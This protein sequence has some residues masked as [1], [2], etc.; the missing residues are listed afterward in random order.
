[1]AGGQQLPE[2][3]TVPQLARVFHSLPHLNVSLHSVNNT[4]NP[5]SE[6]YLESLGI[7][8]SI[9]AAWLILTLLVLLVYLVTRCCDRK[10]R[11][12]RS[13]TL[14][15]CSLAILA[16]LCSGAVAVG[17][18]GNDDVHNGLVQLVA[19]A[20]NVDGI[21]MGVRNQTDTIETTL[22]KKVQLQLTALGDDFDAPVSNK[23]MLGLLLA[24]LQS[25]KQ[26]T[27]IAVNRSFEI[28]KPLSG[29]SLAG[30]IGM[31]EKIEQLRWPVTMAVLSALL[32]LCVVLVVGVARHS[33]CVLITFSVFGLFAVIVSWL[34]ASLYLATSV[35]LGD[36]C[37]SPDGYLTRAVPATL[38]SEVLSYYTHCEN[39]RN[40][41]FSQRLNDG[42]IAA[43]NMR[44]NMSTVTR[45]A[46]ELF[47]EQQ[48]QPKLT[49]LSIDVN[50][51]NKLMSGLTT[52]LDCKPLHKQYVHAAKSLCH[53]GL[54]GLT[55][56]LLASLA[57]GLFFTVLV[58]VDSH[59]WIYI[60]KRR[61]YH[62]VDE[63]DPYLPPSAASQ[64]IAARTL[65]GQGSYPPTA[66]SVFY[67]N[68]HGTQN[69]IKQP[70]LLTP[71]PPSYATATA[72]AR[73]L[74]ESMLKGGGINGSGGGGD[75]KSS[76]HNQQSTGGRAEHRSGLGDQPG[77]YATLSKQCKTLESSDFY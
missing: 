67:P 4:F 41:P 39:T 73:Q 15:K 62:Q 17:L 6:I 10:P 77:Q 46:L 72:R 1:M 65:R 44:D 5:H 47:K 51:V 40:N 43:N 42:Q 19:A 2:Q 11:P 22:K 35:A 18:Y 27:N 13:I 55:F 61:D 69:T 64:A 3:Y 29:I 8:G 23:T 30:A 7:L 31:G 9:P 28:R 52:L 54:Y 76:Q 53:L 59:T 37:V 34:M 75:H 58:W 70:L 12:R 60:R 38:A 24:A 50:T 45:L 71:P 68:A 33:R 26:N 32:V 25:M 49:S 63:Q 66:P 14:L 16:L 56:M 36:L 74:H 48:L 20:K 21:L 57:A